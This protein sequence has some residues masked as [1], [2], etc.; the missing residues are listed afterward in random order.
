MSSLA[1]SLGKSNPPQRW[2][3]C[4]L[5]LELT[6]LKTWR[7]RFSRRWPDYESN[8]TH[9]TYIQCSEPM[10]LEY[11]YVEY[12]RFYIIQ[13]QCLM[14]GYNI[15][16]SGCIY[17]I[18]KNTHIKKTSCACVCVL[19]PCISWS[20]ID[21]IILKN[22]FVG[23]GGSNS[24]FLVFRFHPSKILFVVRCQYFLGWKIRSSKFHQ[25]FF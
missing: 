23:G 8:L 15:F 3:R 6:G 24:Q 22:V 21:R 5:W 11:S 7:Y 4:I 19:I 10:G 14:Y 9:I 1:H 18:Y 17:I 13:W 20:L 16:L 12:K 25:G 2:S